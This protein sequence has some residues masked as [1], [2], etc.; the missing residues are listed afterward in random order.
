MARENL[1]WAAANGAL[2][3]WEHSEGHA[4]IQKASSPELSAWPLCRNV[5]GIFVAL[6]LEDFAG[7]FPGGFF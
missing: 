6:I 3:N 4:H 7:D 1:F 5:S 2:T